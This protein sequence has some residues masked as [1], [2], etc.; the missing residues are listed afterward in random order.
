MLK[1]FIMGF[2]CQNQPSVILEPPPDLSQETCFPALLL[3][4]PFSHLLGWT[5]G[6]GGKED[7]EMQS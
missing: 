5:Q 3:T 4:T 7:W 1:T 2:P 6:P